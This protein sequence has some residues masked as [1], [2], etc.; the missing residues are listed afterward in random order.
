M[1]TNSCTVY[2]VLKTY[3]SIKLEYSKANGLIVYKKL[4]NMSYLYIND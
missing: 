4:N 1:E 3:S 2:I